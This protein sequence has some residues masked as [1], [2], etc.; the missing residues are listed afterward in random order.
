MMSPQFR[1]IFIVSIYA[2]IDV[3]CIVLAFYLVLQFR[4]QTVP[5]KVSLQSL[6]SSDD[7]FKMLFMVWTLL[8]LFF[9]YTHGLYQT[10]REQL[11]SLE[12]WEVVKSTVISTLVIIVLA[13]LLRIQD[14]PRSVMILNAIVITVFCSVWRVLKRLLVN[15]LVSNGY[16]NFNT[17]I[18]GGGKTGILLANEISRQPALGLKIKG[19]L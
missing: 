6:F 3:V 13:F 9:H 12:I 1:A 14:F 5:F 2:A 11:E 16:N 15:Y 10:R 19:F 7:P 4:P 17:L 18:I 8:I